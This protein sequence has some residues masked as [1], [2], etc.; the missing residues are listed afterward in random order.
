[1]KRRLLLGMLLLAGLTASAQD[2]GLPNGTTAPD[3]TATDI[4]GET[5]SLSEYLAQGKT[6]VLYISATWC[7]PCWQFHNTHYLSDVYNTYGMGET[8]S[9]DVVILYVE[10][11]PTT[12]LDNLNGIGPANKTQ[13]DWVTGTPYPILDNAQIANDYQIAFFPTIYRICPEDGKTTQI[14]RATPAGLVA[15]IEDGCSA[16]DGIPNRVKAESQDK[17]YCSTEGAAVGYITNLGSPVTSATA[18]L[19]KDGVAVET[20]EF[21][22]LDIS[23]YQTGAIEFT[24]NTFD[25]EAEYQV[26]ITS[27]NGGT[28]VTLED[29]DLV[30]GNFSLGLGNATETHNN[31][32]V[33]VHTDAWP[34]EIGW[35]ILDSNN[36][37]EAGRN[38]YNGNPNG[39]SGG[40]DANKSITDYISLPGAG[41]YSVVMTDDYGDGWTEGSTQH[42]MEIFSGEDLVFSQ[43]D[44]QIGAGLLFEAELQSDGVLGTNAVQAT[45]AFAVYP[46]PTTGTLNFATNESVDVTVIDITGK[47]VF[48]KK[49]VNNGESVNI[50]NLQKGM[51]IAKIKGAT[52]EKVEKIILN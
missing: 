8:G 41:C 12:N 39:N 26:E 3:F 47:T 31:L 43:T 28:P 45:S 17:K 15:Q 4:N 2:G 18:I 9:E 49:G 22:G 24:S 30:S 33:V 11:D 6:V 36:N 1:M 32:K 10:G 14:Q 29:G 5:H 19:K 7:G 48:T 35:R 25:A 51:Y 46:N 34:Y 20:K 40:P 23:A 38:N 27:I 21:T 16:L 42:G 50:G 13:G 52:A 37:Q 44:G